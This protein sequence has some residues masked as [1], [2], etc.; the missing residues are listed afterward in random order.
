M[1]TFRPA[2][3]GQA[4]VMIGLAGPSRSGKTF[5]ALRIA[6]GLA[7]GGPIFFIDTERGRALQ[8]AD[9]FDFLHAE[10]NEP[11]SAERYMEGIDQAAAADAAVII[12]DSASHLHEGPGG[13]LEQQEAELER[14]AGQDFAKRERVK[15]AA[16]I[17]P[18]AAHNRYVN[19]ILQVNTHMIFCFRAKDKLV[20]AKGPDGKT[21]PLSVGWTPICTDRFEYEMTAMLVLPEGGQGTPDLEAKSTGLR[22]PLDTM[23]EANK[24]LDESLGE[25]LAK[26]AGGKKAKPAKKAEAKKDEPPAL[27]DEGFFIQKKD[28]LVE[29]HS[30]E[31][32]EGKMLVAIKALPADRCATFRTRNGPIMGRLHAEGFE[33]QIDAVEDAFEAKIGESA[34]DELI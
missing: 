30:I 17:K 21:Q 34:Q 14:M 26:W 24:Q 15:F 8:Y 29:C 28:N 33:K 27:P 20:M 22:T 3:R 32:W 6:T 4:S 23:I 11:F 10:L 7:S 12:V 31:D 1:F 25:K 5:S 9:N 18:K 13:I 19:A 16:W 2:K